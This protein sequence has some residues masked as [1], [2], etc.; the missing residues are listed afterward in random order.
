MPDRKPKTS[1]DDFFLARPF[2]G[3]AFLHLMP[4]AE[5]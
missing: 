1:L 2:Q 3:P 4:D 5:K